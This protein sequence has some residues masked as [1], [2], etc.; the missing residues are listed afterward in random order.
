MLTV[1]TC[2]GYLITLASIHVVPMLV[3]WLGWG[4]AFA[5][6]AAGPVVGIAAMIRL[7]GRP[8]A[9]RL[10]SGRY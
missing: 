5:A 8:E 9:V 7:R 10:A 6:L 3:T 1:Q 4:W 2:I